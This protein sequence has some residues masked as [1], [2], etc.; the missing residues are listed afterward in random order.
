MN[1]E[2]CIPALLLTKL[3]KGHT[4]NHSDSLVT[5]P[6]MTTER[7][8]TTIS[9]DPATYDAFIEMAQKQ[10]V[11][12]SRWMGD[13]LA[14]T[15]ESAQF[16]SYKMDQLRRAPSESMKALHDKTIAEMQSYPATEAASPRLV[17]RG[18]T[19]PPKVAD[20]KAKR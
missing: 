10:G 11:S 14:S 20:K 4:V 18:V 1:Q 15:M 9:I 7:V 5:P 2:M 8:R 12:V 6:T 19:T 16:V 3:Q 17:I 13:W